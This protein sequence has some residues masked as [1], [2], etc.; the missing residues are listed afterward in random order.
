MDEE[1]ALLL[2][3]VENQNK[4]TY[5]DSDFITGIYFGQEVVVCKSGIGKVNAAI[6]TQILID[7]FEVE[8]IIFTG[9]AGAAEPSL[10]IGDIVISSS[11]QQH[12]MDVTALGHAVGITPDQEVS[13][14]PADAGLIK[15]AEQ[16]CLSLGQDC[17]YIIG[18]V[19]SGDQFIADKGIVNKLHETF[20]GACVEMEG[21]AVAQVCHRNKIPYVVIRAMSDK[22]DGSA[23]M[24]YPDFV[25]IAAD[26]SFEIIQGIFKQL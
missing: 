23:H 8:E 16:S 3:Q 4:Q 15:L 17:H 25:V 24:N 11:C 22:A 12:D 14:F 26:R 18:K 7:R 10:N 13:D 19:L 9:V 20:D 21:A 2:A 1:L 5:A 6:N